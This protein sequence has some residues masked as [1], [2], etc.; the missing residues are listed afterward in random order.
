MGKFFKFFFGP[1]LVS[2]LFYNTA[3]LSAEG[4]ITDQ[5]GV[6]VLNNKIYGA[7]P[8]G[9]LALFELSAGEE[10]IGIES[11][12]INALVR[13][14][15]RLLGFSG[16]LQQWS[17]R[18]PNLFDSFIESI[19][20]PQLIFVRNQKTLYGFQGLR[21]QWKKEELDTHEEFKEVLFGENLV[22]AITNRRVLALSAFTGGFF[23]RDLSR[24]EEFLDKVVNDNI[25]ILTTSQRRL[26]FRSKLAVWAELR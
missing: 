23:L 26:I 11:R 13:T 2:F 18:R 4:K 15:T 19:V 12:G 25:A 8:S 1:I 22:V 16:P 9:Q 7:A 10:V 21:A 17:E 24:Q 3:D 20:T 14:S 6:A 5:V